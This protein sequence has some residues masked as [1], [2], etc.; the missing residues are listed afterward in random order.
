MENH[1]CKTFIHVT[2]PFV[3]C[4]GSMIIF[5]SGRWGEGE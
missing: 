4:K 3:V 5:C 1:A 2:A